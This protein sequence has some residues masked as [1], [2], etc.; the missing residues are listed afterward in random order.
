MQIVETLKL[1]EEQKERIL[2]LWNEEYPEQLKYKELG[3]FN[4]YLD[5]LLQKKHYLLIS[6][7][8]EVNGWAFLFERDK[9]TWFALLLS[10]KMQGKGIGTKLLKKIQA[11][12]DKLNGWVIDHNRDKKYNGEIYKSPLGFYLKNGFTIGR[13]Q[14]LETEK[15]S[16][17]KVVWRAHK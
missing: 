5:K 1:T 3:E 6:Q 13:G 11:D 4:H 8:N 2:T 15:I 9:E 12:E 17:V 14:R 16:A 7:E 10:S